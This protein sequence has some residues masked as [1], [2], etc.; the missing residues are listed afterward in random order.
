[1]DIFNLVT[2]CKFCNIMKGNKIPKDYEEVILRL[3]LRAVQDN[4]IVKASLKIP[5]KELNV[6]L[7]KVDKIEDLTD[8]FIF[9]SY[10]KRFY[11]KN[12]KVFKVVHL[13]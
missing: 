13:N 9:Q 6:E 12:N 3:F 11:I 8:Y 1:M 4:R 5:Q 2:C 7:S 10:N